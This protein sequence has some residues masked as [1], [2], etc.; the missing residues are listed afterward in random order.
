MTTLRQAVI[1]LISWVLCGLAMAGHPTRDGGVEM[2]HGTIEVPSGAPLP[3]IKLSLFQDDMSGYNLQ[4]KVKAFV[5]RP[6]IPQ[7]AKHYPIL[8][9]H[10][11]LFING[12]KIQR[13]YGEYVHLPAALFNEGINTITV[14]LNNHKHATWTAT[15]VE[16]QSTLTIDRRKSPVLLH[17]YSSSPL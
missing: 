6:P 4:I 2:D 11:H 9:G 7:K 8:E 1:T 5:I 3:G 13:V 12:V 16:I 10:A 17:Q 14:S 15:A